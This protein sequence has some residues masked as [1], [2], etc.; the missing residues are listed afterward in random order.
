MEHNIQIFVTSVHI[1]HFQDIL[2]TSC[3]KYTPSKKKY[4]CSD[5]VGW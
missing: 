3:V 4:Y 2:K 1:S 5:H